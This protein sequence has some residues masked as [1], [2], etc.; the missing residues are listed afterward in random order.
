MYELM[1]LCIHLINAIKLVHPRLL[2]EAL[3]H[4]QQNIFKI[5]NENE[6]KAVEGYLSYCGW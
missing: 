3:P 1:L 6:L 5:L 2:A 4:L